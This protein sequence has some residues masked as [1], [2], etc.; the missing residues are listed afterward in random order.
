MTCERSCGC[1]APTGTLTIGKLARLA[2]VSVDTLRFYEKQGLL[3]PAGKSEA[4]YRLYQQDALRRLHFIRHA[5]RCGLSLAEIG[6][7]LELKRR[8]DACCED[9]RTVADQKKLQIENKI[10]SLKA[11]SQAL[12]ELIEVCA[13]E[14][15]PLDECPILAALEASLTK[16]RRP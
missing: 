15:K 1:D 10:K 5:Q 16:G 3:R 9:V 6:D 8:D 11:M 2:A 14:R 13:G 12:S 4:G 7:L